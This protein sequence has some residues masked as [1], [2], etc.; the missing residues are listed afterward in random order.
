MKTL[1]ATLFF[2]FSA[3]LLGCAPYDQLI[4]RPDIYVSGDFRGPRSPYSNF[5]DYGL[6]FPYVTIVPVNGTPFELEIFINGKRADISLEGSV[7]TKRIPPGMPAQ[8]KAFVDYR[9]SR[10]LSVVAVAYKSN[11]VVGSANRV[12]YFYGH[13][14]AEQVEDWPIRIWDLRD[15]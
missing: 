9:V 13:A 6:Y 3:F 7:K 15:P 12:F 5:Y 8:I 14:N 1:K 2:L 11:K 4:V 10:Q